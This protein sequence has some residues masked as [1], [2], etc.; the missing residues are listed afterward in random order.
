MYENQFFDCCKNVKF[1][2]IFYLRFEINLK[3]YVKKAP[4]LIS[5]N[6]FQSEIILYSI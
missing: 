2:I 1:P 3:C 4:H 6:F 5:N